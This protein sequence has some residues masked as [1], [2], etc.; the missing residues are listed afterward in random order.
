MRLLSGKYTTADVA[1]ALQGKTAKVFYT[2]LVVL[3][4]AVMGYGLKK[5][6]YDRQTLTTQAEELKRQIA[7]LQ[8]DLQK[9]RKTKPI[10]PPKK[11]QVP[12][13]VKKLEYEYGL[14]PASKR[15]ITKKQTVKN[16]VFETAV[17]TVSY[18]YVDYEQFKEF[19][20]RLQ[21]GWL[22][23]KGLKKTGKYAEVQ[24]EVFYTGK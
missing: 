11:T 17:F 22:N 1:V 2:V 12:I 16:Q 4:V 20:R 10:P 24:Y 14:I 19:L 8:S 23:L 7:A 18:K 21:T 9:Y 13:F 3:A 15:M 6:L 5:V